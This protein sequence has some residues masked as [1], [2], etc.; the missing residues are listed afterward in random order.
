MDLKNE[1][2]NTIINTEKSLNEHRSKLGSTD[3]EEIEREL[4]TLKNM[5]E[6]K[7]LTYND[8]SKLREAI[9]KGKKAASKIGEAMY[10]NTSSGQPQGGQ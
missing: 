6:N 1:A 9:D 2:E 3:I 5:H 8:S 4:Q 10:R 7:T